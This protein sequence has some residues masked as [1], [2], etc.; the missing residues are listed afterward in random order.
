MNRLAT[1]YDT[2]VVV[3]VKG[4]SGVLRGTLLS[5]VDHSMDYV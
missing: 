4:Q 3:G 1:Q 2:P 5:T